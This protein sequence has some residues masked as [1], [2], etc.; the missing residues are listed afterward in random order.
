MANTFYYNT[1]LYTPFQ[2]D[3]ASFCASNI[4]GGYIF[5]PIMH[6]SPTL[7]EFHPQTICTNVLKTTEPEETDKEPVSA[8]H[9]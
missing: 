9:C 5:L 2:L 1:L 8:L 3:P 4:N 6:S 7:L